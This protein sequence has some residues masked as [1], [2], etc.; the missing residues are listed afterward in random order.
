MGTVYSSKMF[1]PI[2]QSTWYYI[3]KFHKPFLGAFA[4]LEKVVV[5]F[6]TSTHL[7]IHME[8]F[9]NNVS[10][11]LHETVCRVGVGVIKSVQKIKIWL[12]SD[13]ITGI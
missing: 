11:D 6:V 2:Y 7:P 8:K 10:M 4:K 9:N 12:K 13:K 3:I 5:S 1:V